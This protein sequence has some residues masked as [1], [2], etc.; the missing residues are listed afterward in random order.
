MEH[1]MPR[2]PIKCQCESMHG[3]QSEDG[4]PCDNDANCKVETVY[5]V[6]L[7]CQPCAKAMPGE[8]LKDRDRPYTFIEPD[9]PVPSTD[10]ARTTDEYEYRQDESGDLLAGASRDRLELSLIRKDTTMKFDTRVRKLLGE[11]DD[12]LPERMGDILME[13]HARAM[14]VAAEFDSGRERDAWMMFAR[15]MNEYA[16]VT[17]DLPIPGRGR[18]RGM[19]DPQQAAE[20]HEEEERAYARSLREIGGT[21]PNGRPLDERGDELEPDAEPLGESPEDEDAAAPFFMVAPYLVWRQCGG[22]EE[23]GWYYDAGEPALEAWLSAPVVCKTRAEAYEVR[24]AMQAALDADANVGLRDK[25]SVLSSG[26]YEAHVTAGYP[27]AFPVE[28]PF[29]E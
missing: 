4:V 26:V 3:G 18:Q 21:G 15:R 6:Y 28:R 2:P 10:K 22:P 27:H 12:A 13:L 20:T 16:H 25:Y 23:G 7:M 24:E 8:F 29:Y 11:A 19:R 14:T 17:I 5:G 1:T 9:E